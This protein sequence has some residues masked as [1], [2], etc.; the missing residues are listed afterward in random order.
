MSTPSAAL[1]RLVLLGLLLLAASGC[2]NAAA[3]E[4]Q[5]RADFDKQVDT[6]WRNNWLWVEGIQF[7]D[8]G[9]IYIDSDEPGHPAYDKPV[10]LPLMKRLS[11]KHGLKWHAVCDKRKRNI[12]VAIVAKIPDQ[13]GVRAAIMEMLSAEQKAFPL[14]I[15][16]QEGNRWLSLD[17]LDAEDAAFL[18]DDEPAK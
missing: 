11:A 1:R 10:V 8:K 17:F 4:L 9:G 3:L 14:D 18:A 7:F 5:A 16:V 13:E 6:T 2:E 15:L 12:A